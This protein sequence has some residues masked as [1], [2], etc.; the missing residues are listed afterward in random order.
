MI[1][2]ETLRDRQEE[3]DFHR[4]KDVK[5]LKLQWENYKPSKQVDLI[6]QFPEIAEGILILIKNL[7]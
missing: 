2:S 5:S 6:R 3:K 7:N 1:S 4:E